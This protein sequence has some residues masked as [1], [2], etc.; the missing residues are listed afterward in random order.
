MENA[1]SYFLY[2][3]EAKEKMFR[4]E[5]IEILPLLQILP[6]Q[7]SKVKLSLCNF[8]GLKEV[9]KDH[10]L[11]YLIFNCKIHVLLRLCQF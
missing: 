8:S 7:V 5:N 3:S 1:L 10:I 4:D 9:K 6:T 2:R 11:F